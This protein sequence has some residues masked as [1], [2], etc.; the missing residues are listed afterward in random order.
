V[1]AACPAPSLSTVYPF[2]NNGAVPLTGS[3]TI[4]G[5]GT[6][7]FTLWASYGRPDD[8]DFNP[9]GY[10]GSDIKEQLT[11]QCVV[12]PGA[13]PPFMY[14]VLPVTA[15]LPEASHGEPF[16][17]TVP[18]NQ[19]GT[20]IIP[21]TATTPGSATMSFNHF[22]GTHPMDFWFIEVYHKPAVG[23]A[24]LVVGPPS[25]PGNYL[26]CKDEA[27]IGGACRPPH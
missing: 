8:S 5:G 2:N 3:A 19:S 10:H 27:V 7:T 16:V 21:P 18:P 6:W 20:T 12:V 25:G 23:P 22:W 9:P 24:V 4:S 17:G 26:N 11:V 14:T 1:A 15:A 13:T